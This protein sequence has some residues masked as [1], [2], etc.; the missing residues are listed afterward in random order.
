MPMIEV[1]Q[2]YIYA[3]DTY[4]IDTHL[5]I[6]VSVCIWTVLMST[7]V[8]GSVGNILVLYIYSNRKDNKTCTLFIKVLAVVDLTICILIA[9]LELYQTTQGI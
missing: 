7:I 3:N 9:P 2:D 1:D 5:Y 6:L 8:F 4:H